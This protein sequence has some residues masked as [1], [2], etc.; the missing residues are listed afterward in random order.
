M[1]ITK[2]V[3]G[4]TESL[5]VTNNLVCEEGGLEEAFGERGR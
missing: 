5:C 4:R 3:S 1:T 2:S